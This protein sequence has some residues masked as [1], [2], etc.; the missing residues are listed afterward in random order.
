MIF[1]GDK[2]FVRAGINKQDVSR[3]FIYIWAN[4]RTETMKGE[5]INV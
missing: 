5:M 2:G 3:F 1:G 4:G